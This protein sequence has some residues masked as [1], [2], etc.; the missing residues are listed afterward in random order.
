MFQTALGKPLA[1]VTHTIGNMTHEN[2]TSMT[3][4][5]G[6]ATNVHGN[7]L[8]GKTEALAEAVGEAK[9]NLLMFAGA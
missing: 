3:T 5:A 2:I 6:F 8:A 4:D 7:L 9:N 1:E